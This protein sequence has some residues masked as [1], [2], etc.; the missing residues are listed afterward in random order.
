MIICL[1]FNVQFFYGYEIFNK[2]LSKYYFFVTC[3]DN[4]FMIF[5]IF[6]IFDIFSIAKYLQKQKIQRYEAHIFT[7]NENLKS[8]FFHRSTLTRKILSLVVR[9][10]LFRC[11]KVAIL[12]RKV[13]CTDKNLQENISKTV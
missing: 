1:T 2:Y 11:E 8:I 3:Q 12:V 6:F 13:F 10:I 5:D 9:K 7:E 4:N